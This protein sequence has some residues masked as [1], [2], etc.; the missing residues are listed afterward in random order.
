MSFEYNLLSLSTCCICTS[1]WINKC[2]PFK[3]YNYCIPHCIYMNL[4]WAT[5]PWSNQWMVPSLLTLLSQWSITEEVVIV[6]SDL[7]LVNFSFTS[8][9]SLFGFYTWWCTQF[10][11]VL[12][13]LYT[14][15]LS[16][17]TMSWIILRPL[18]CSLIDQKYIH[19]I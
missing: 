5:N 15:L 10:P 13:C 1:P 19:Y 7:V 18:W 3:K 4:T 8:N 12:I 9:S 11:C 2:Q 14:P 6:C 16:S 17:C